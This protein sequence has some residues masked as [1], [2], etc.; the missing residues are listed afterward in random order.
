MTAHRH[1]LRHRALLLACLLMAALPTWGQFSLGLGLHGGTTHVG[2][3]YSVHRGGR[4]SL[5]LGYTLTEQLACELSAGYWTLGDREER[6]QGAWSGQ[7]NVDTTV[8]TRLHQTDLA[9][10]LQYRPSKWFE[11]ALGTSLGLLQNATVRTQVTYRS[12]STTW[13]HSTRA[14]QTRLFPRLDW[15]LRPSVAC[16]P[17]PALAI[18]LTLHMGLTNLARPGQDAYPRRSH[19]ILLGIDWRLLA[20]GYGICLDCVF[21]GFEGARG[22]VSGL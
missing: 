21:W 20:R 18:R 7:E 11:F 19:G 9:L 8:F 14:D 12:D 2:S 17:Q 3:W 1:P 4:A 5:A 10:A 15:G 16:Y 13:G 22:C 6:A